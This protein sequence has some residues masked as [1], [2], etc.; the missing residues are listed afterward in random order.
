MH[1]PARHGLGV[2]A[3]NRD[4]AAGDLIEA[5]EQVDHG[6][7]AGTGRADDGDLL[8]GLDG[9]GEVVDDRLARLVAELHVAEFHVALHVAPARMVRAEQGLLAGFVLHLRLLKEAEHAFG[10]RRATLQVLEGLGELRQRLGEQ[11]DVHHERHDHAELDLAVE[12]E[13]RAH[14]AHHHV[15]EVTHEVHERHHQ[16]GE[17]L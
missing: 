13:R 1:V 5:H 6:G 2:H 3:V 10:G 15:A 16:A 14:H 7:L 17:E 8:P 4:R 12:C 11:A 9:G